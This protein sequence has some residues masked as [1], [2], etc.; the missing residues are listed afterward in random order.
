MAVSAIVPAA[1]GLNRVCHHLGQNRSRQVCH[2]GTYSA[3]GL[4]DVPRRFYGE[5][6]HEPVAEAITDEPMTINSDQRQTSLNDRW[7]KPLRRCKTLVA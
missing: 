6:A 1:A 5:F 3:Y 4:D 2:P 7:Y